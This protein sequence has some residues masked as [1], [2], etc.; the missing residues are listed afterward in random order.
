M[1]MHSLTTTY[2]SDNNTDQ[3]LASSREDSSSAPHSVPSISTL[4][5]NIG[6]VLSYSGHD[7]IG[8]PCITKCKIIAADAVWNDVTNIWYPQYTIELQG[9]MQ[10]ITVHENTLFFG[11]GQRKSKSKGEH[12]KVG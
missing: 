6:D 5:F 9:S 2:T 10:R 4:R 11:N 3:V 12:V 8:Q 7:S 1:D